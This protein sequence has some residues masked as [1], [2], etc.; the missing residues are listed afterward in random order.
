M[1]DGLEPV[2]DFAEEFKMNYLVAM[3][4]DKLGETFGGILGLPTTFLVGRDGRIY[5]K[6]VGGTDVSAFEE[7]VK[8]LLADEAQL[9]AARRNK[10]F[11]D[12][13]NI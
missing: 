12:F 3:G 4:G 1:D 8:K 13:G 11:Q 10:T 6:H 9:V 5:A 2:R 7:E